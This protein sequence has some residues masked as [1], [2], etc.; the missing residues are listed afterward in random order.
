[1]PREVRQ[2]SIVDI[3]LVA[4]IRPEST[5]LN[6]W[7]KKIKIEVRKAYFQSIDSDVADSEADS[8][9]LGRRKSTLILSLSS[10]YTG[11]G[12]PLPVV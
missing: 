3:G 5:R 9:T 1:M 7:K 2:S 4:N 6:Q 10:I 12:R 11:F 8:P